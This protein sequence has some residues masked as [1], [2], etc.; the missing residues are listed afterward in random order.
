M[1][2]LYLIR[3]AEAESN[4]NPDICG[5]QSIRVPLTPRGVRQAA[6]LQERLAREDVVFDVI[7]RSTADRT[8]MTA[9]YALSSQPTYPTHTA[10]ENLLEIHQGAFTGKAWS[11]VYTPDVLAAIK[12]DPWT[13]RSPGGESQEDVARRMWRE[14]EDLIEMFHRQ[15]DKPL[16]A[17]F[18]TH[19]LAIKAWMRQLLQFDKRFTWLI[20]I[21]N[22]S[23]TQFNYRLVHGK[24]VWIPVRVNDAAHIR[25]I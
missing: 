8:A 19:G 17:A 16:T 9:L 5:G 24:H 22:A 6:A 7:R 21:D 2:E 25:G 1:L 14:T 3:H 20:E 18:V 13:F 23:I 10:T 11:Q 4:L 12:A 15:G